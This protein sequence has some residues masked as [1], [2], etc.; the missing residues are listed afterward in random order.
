M[1][2]WYFSNSDCRLR[3]GD[4]RIIKAGITHT[5]DCEPILCKQGLHGSVNILDALS[6]ARGPRIW[7]VELN[8]NVIKSDDKAAATERPYLWGYDATDVLRHFARLCALDVIHLWKAPDVEMRYL[9]TGDEDLR[10]AAWCAAQGTSTARCAARYAAFNGA[11]CSAASAASAAF[12]GAAYS[13][14][15]YAASAVW[16]AARYTAW[17]TASAARD[18]ARDKQSRR[19]YRMIMQDRPK[20]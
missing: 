5:V 9:K 16:D 1:K 6:Y 19:L 20:A 7:R 13:A 18:A 2:A 14:A 3:H 10:H 15:R 11:A 12:N 8:G 4:N 17:D